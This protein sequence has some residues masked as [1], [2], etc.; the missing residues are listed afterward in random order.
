MFRVFRR[1]RFE[2]SPHVFGLRRVGARLDEIDSIRRFDRTVL[3]SVEQQ[4]KTF[5]RFFLSNFSF[6]GFS[7]LKL[8]FKS[9][10]VCFSRLQFFLYRLKSS[11]IN[12]E[13]LPIDDFLYRSASIDKRKQNRSN[14]LFQLSGRLSCSIFSVILK[15]TP[16][17]VFHNWNKFSQN[18]WP[19][20]YRI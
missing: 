17:L 4:R 12:G 20:R 11:A 14:F 5:V 9:L 7:R 3:F 1:N 15:S 8:K 13:N 6:T 10:V 18:Q 2:T 19:S 16:F